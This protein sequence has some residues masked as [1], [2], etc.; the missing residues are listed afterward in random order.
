MWGARARSRSDSRSEPSRPYGLSGVISGSGTRPASR[1]AGASAGSALALGAFLDGIPEQLVLGIGLASGAGVGVGLLAAIFVSNLPEGIGSASEMRAKG[2][3]GV[4]PA[5]WVA[6]A[7]VCTWP[8]S[9]GTR[10]GFAS[11]GSSGGDQRLRRGRPP[12][13][14]RRLDDPERDAA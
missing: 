5:V 6:V 13:D 4:G 10:S 12:G 8:P 11:G 1:Q 9:R 2:A 7:L 14:A 3:A